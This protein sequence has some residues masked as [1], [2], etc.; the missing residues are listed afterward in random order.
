[1]KAKKSNRLWLLH[2]AMG[3]AADWREFSASLPE[4]STRAVDLWRRLECCPKS[5]EEVGAQLNAEAVAEGCDAYLLA[6][7]MGAR[8]ALHALCAK[9]SP[10]KGAILVAPHPGLQTEPER[11]A[12]RA[13][14]AEWGARALSGDWREFCAAWQAQPVLAG[15]EISRD[16]LISRR[17]EIARS[18]L[19]W[20][21]GA[22]VPL[23]EK[24]PNIS[25]PVLWVTGAQD[26]KFSALAQQAVP[27]ISHATWHVVP[28]AGHRVPWQQPEE[29]SRVTRE[30]LQQIGAF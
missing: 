21:L 26:E 18:F 3:E 27:Q 9:N 16:G 15:A 5:L 29:F 13:M 10:W 11:A 12:R 20:S 23:W 8:I 24:L 30:F 28:E 2:G 22:Q 14:D 25:C 7:S 19:D 17:R 1:M 6:Y 4:I